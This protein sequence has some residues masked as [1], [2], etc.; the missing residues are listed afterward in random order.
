MTVLKCLHKHSAR[1]FATIVAVAASGL[2]GYLGYLQVSGNFHTVVPG[3]LY[4]S[5]RPTSHELERYAR[6]YGIKTV[7]NLLG[8]NEGERWYEEESE[9]AKRLGLK[10]L[11]F[12]MSSSTML[13]PGQADQLVTLLKTA[14]KPILVH[15]KAG[16]DRTG[17]VSVIYS[18][19]I[20]GISE[21]IAERQLSLFFGHFSIPFISSAYAMDE[22]WEELERHYGIGS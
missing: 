8:R 22:S 20:A 13:S 7:V 17:L 3:E 2:G 11:D 6:V 15:C 10:L 19:R 4:R 9:A 12:K 5:G 1:V 14:P 21:E 16:A 18:E